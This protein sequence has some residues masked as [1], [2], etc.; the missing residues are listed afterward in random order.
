M[1]NSDLKE[2]CP[3]G[4]ECHSGHCH[5]AGLADTHTHC[6]VSMVYCWDTQSYVMNKLKRLQVSNV[7]VIFVHMC[8]YSYYFLNVSNRF[9]ITKI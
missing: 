2:Q 5:K 4:Y 8:V 9:E 1:F 6:T 3:P 7:N